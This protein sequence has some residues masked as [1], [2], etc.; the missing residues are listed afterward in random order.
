MP[1]LVALSLPPGPSYRDAI[2]QVWQAGDAFAPLDP[3]L[4]DDEQQRLLEA[5][6]P[7]ELIGADGTRSA[8]E[9]GH[10][11]D[12]GDALVIATSG[13][14]G[15]PKG[16]VH[17]HASIRA[18]AKATSRALDVRPES[19]KWLACLPL[20]HIGGLSVVLRS[21]VTSTP[22]EIHDGFNPAAVIDA[23]GRGA[24]LVSLVTR[25]LQQVPASIFRTVLIGGA[26]PPT[27]LAEN[28]VA[29]YGMTETGSGIIYSTP[30]GQLV[31][32]GAELR[33]DTEGRIAVSGPMLARCYRDGTSL[34]DSEGWF[35]TGDLGSW[36]TH[37]D[38]VVAGRAGD[39]I[40]TGAEKVWPTPIEQWLNR[41]ADIHEVA[42]VGLP[43]PEW[44]H[45]VTAV[46]VPADSAQPPSLE[47]LKADV[48][49]RFAP[50]AAPKQLVLRGALPRTSIGK[51]QRRQLVT[52][53]LAQL[54]QAQGPQ[55]S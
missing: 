34:T 36:N 51:L 23:A 17:T 20:A 11:V 5:L 33:I 39:V 54:E 26:S 9:G 50:W 16:V 8:L 32:D 24:N 42:L 47:E 2:D 4:P 13:T 28:V 22:V 14:T 43:D 40:V 53:L 15:A 21:M 25:A 49:D 19:D 29:T 6:R 48:R 12:D 3:R 37:G 38:L 46:V 44:G 7:H 1:R 41:R 52:E 35:I 18:S 10:P 31:L 30:H 45:R 27:G 55:D